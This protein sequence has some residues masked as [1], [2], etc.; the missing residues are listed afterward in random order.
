M[1]GWQPGNAW[2]VR[3]HAEKQQ[4]VGPPS[5]MALA[6]GNRG[7]G[8]SREGWAGRDKF[9]LQTLGGCASCLYCSWRRAHS[10]NRTF[11]LQDD[12]IWVVG[13]WLISHFICQSSHPPPFASFSAG[14]I[15]AYTTLAVSERRGYG[16]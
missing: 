1:L 4:H 13:C 15:P 14:R 2:I 9:M 16:A 3:F 6:L 11:V 10:S 7:G 8:E 5:P 12:W